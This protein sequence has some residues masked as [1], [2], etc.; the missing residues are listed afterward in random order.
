VI[1]S[2]NLRRKV[3]VKKL[4]IMAD[5]NKG[6]LRGV[7]LGNSWQWEAEENVCSG[8]RRLNSVEEP[9]AQQGLGDAWWANGEML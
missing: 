8:P 7:F 3:A 2:F 4:I 9:L 5:K 6:A 1:Y